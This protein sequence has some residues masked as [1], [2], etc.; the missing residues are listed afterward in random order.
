M[1]GIMQWLPRGKANGG[2]TAG[3]KPVKNSDLWIALERIAQV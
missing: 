3:K 1:D 2:K